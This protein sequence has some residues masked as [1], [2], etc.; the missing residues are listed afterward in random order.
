MTEQVQLLAMA[1]DQERN[2]ARDKP[3]G[4][5]TDEETKIVPLDV[6]NQHCGARFRE[7]RG[8]I[9]HRIISKLTIGVTSNAA[10]EKK[11]IAPEPRLIHPR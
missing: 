9:D 6:R 8:Q 11:R 5:M 1:L 10:P 2:V 3:G 4:A 7:G